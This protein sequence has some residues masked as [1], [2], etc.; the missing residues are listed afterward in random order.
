MEKVIRYPMVYILT[1]IQRI[2]NSTETVKIKNSLL[3]S[4]TA[5]FKRVWNNVGLIFHQSEACSKIFQR[6]PTLPKIVSSKEANNVA[7]NIIAWL[8]N[9]TRWPYLMNEV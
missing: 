1:E 5:S 9:T 4:Y 8:T 7:F 3:I 6:Q 2:L